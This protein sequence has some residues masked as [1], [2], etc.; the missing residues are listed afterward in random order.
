[1]LNIN[2]IKSNWRWHLIKRVPKWG[3]DHVWSCDLAV[4]TST[5][6]HHTTWHMKFVDIPSFWGSVICHESVLGPLPI[7]ATWQYMIHE[8]WTLM[9]AVMWTTPE[10][11]V[12]VDTL[13]LI[14]QISNKTLH[15]SLTHTLLFCSWATVYLQPQ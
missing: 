1:M 9:M 11:S 4:A 8:H 14:F 6:V 2:N 15:N 7:M 3:T 5:V 13:N 10:T 12:D